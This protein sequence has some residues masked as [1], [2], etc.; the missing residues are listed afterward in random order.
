[1]LCGEKRTRSAAEGLAGVEICLSAIGGLSVIGL[2]MLDVFHRWLAT[3]AA[4]GWVGTAVT[5]AFFLLS[6]GVIVLIGLLSGFE[7]PLLIALRNSELGSLS[8]ATR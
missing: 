6:H 5:A 7:I 3:S 4:D 8:V 1:M 2:C